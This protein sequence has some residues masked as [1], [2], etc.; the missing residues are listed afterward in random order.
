[1]DTFPIKI[2]ENNNLTRTNRPVRLGIPFPRGKVKNLQQ[3]ELINETGEQLPFQS[4]ITAHWDDQSFRWILIDF[5]TSIKAN[6][7]IQYQINITSKS[8]KSNTNKAL[9]YSEN[10]QEIVVAT[11]VASFQIDKHNFTPFNKITTPL[12]DNLI[13]GSKTLLVDDSGELLVSTIEKIRYPQQDQDQRLTIEFEGVFK[14]SKTPFLRFKSSLTFFVG[15]A[16]CE[17]DFTLHNP[18]RTIHPGGFW[19]MGDPGSKYFKSLAISLGLPENTE[20]FWKNL[21]ETN[22]SKLEGEKIRLYQDSSG[23]ENWK[24]HIHIDKDGESTV[25]FRGYQLISDDKTIKEGLRASPV[26]KMK[27]GHGHIQATIIKFWQNF[28]KA[29]TR[30]KGNLNIELFPV[31]EVKCFHELQGGEQKTHAVL[32]N[33]SDQLGAV[34]EYLTSLNVTLPLKHYYHSNAMPWLP[35]NHQPDPLDTIIQEGLI[36]ESSFF[37]K[38]EKADEYGWRNFGEL[39]ADHEILEH[40]NDETLVSHYNNQ[41]DPI[42]SFAKQYLLTG[43]YRWLELMDDLAKHVVDIDIYHTDQD[44]PQLNN[45]LFWHTDHYLDAQTCTHRSISR[46]HLQIDHVSQSGGGPGN[47]HCYTAG[48]LYHYLLTGNENSRESLLQISEWCDYANNG[49]GSFLETLKIFICKDI[50]KFSRVLTGNNVFKHLYPLTRGTGNY[51]NTVLDLYFLKN[52]LTQLKKA[53]SIINATF[54]FHDDINERYLLD[55]ENNWSYTVFLQSV[56]KYLYII[57]KT[58]QTNSDYNYILKSFIYYISWLVDNEE[59]YLIN[60]IKLD[61]PNDTWPAQDLRKIMLLKFARKYI[62]G[63]K[64][65]DKINYLE[66]EIQLQLIHSEERLTTRVM[67]LIIQN[68]FK[69]DYE[70]S[71]KYGKKNTQIKDYGS[72]SQFHT[73]TSLSLC[74]LNRLLKSILSC[75]I[76]NEIK[77]IQDTYRNL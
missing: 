53:E 52:D 75:K 37:S 26:F 5:L 64:L 50:K 35:E 3:L 39:W 69:S 67:A 71:D 40:G 56:A 1:M 22:F 41:Y 63:K 70:N 27:T 38:R 14:K 31:T 46:K 77:W 49:G 51:V 2:Q 24:H 11:G 17:L 18:D 44:K 61:Y 25:S 54:S 36:G 29:L 12:S 76:K 74:T 23:G 66:S 15:S 20:T 59:P 19:D 48:L 62:P 55:V 4:K 8:H 34:T 16:L 47:E 7:T 30:D 21:E 65:E 68:N 10:E 72:E 45:G 58:E 28:P 57:E 73:F 33:F 42:Y 9:G 43:D 13:K 6:Q 32:L 60:S